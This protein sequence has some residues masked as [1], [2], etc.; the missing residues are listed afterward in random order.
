MTTTVVSNKTELLDALSRAGGGDTIVLKNGHYGSLKITADFSSTVT[1]RAEDRLG[2][3]ISG[4]ELAGATNLTFDG[5]NF[6]SGGNGGHGRGIVSA[7]YGSSGIAVVNSE[8]HGSDDNTYQG[9]YGLY[10]R[11]SNNVTFR[12]NDV[13]DVD[14]GIVIFG[15]SGSEISGN[16]V[17]YFGRDAMKFAG[18]RSSEVADNISY[19]HVYK[20]GTA[21]TDF[22]QFQGS[23][24]NVRIAGNAFLAG[25]KG[26]VQGIFLSDGTYTGITI[27]NNLIYTGMARGISISAGS[28][29][30]I[31]SNTLLNVPGV[32]HNQTVILAPGATVQDNI[33]TS[34]VGKAI[35]SNLQLQNR[36]PGADYYVE[37]YF[38]NPMEGLGASLKDLAPIAGSLGASKGADALL[39]A[40]VG[41]AAPTPS[42]PAPAPGPSAPAPAPTPIPAPAWDEIEVNAGGPA[43]NGFAA[44]A[45]YFRGSSHK[46]KAA[47]A[48]TAA[49]ALYQTERYGNFKYA[50]DVED[51]TY[52]VTLKMAEIYWGAAGKRVFDVKAEGKVVLDNFDI[53][54]AAG[55]KNIAHDETFTVEV[56]DGRLDLDFVSLV[57]NAKVSA[58]AVDLI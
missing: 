57:N 41:G 5:I 29:N 2:A 7:D 15:S 23:S 24:S 45:F 31:E 36:N 20:I 10:A 18:L 49:D 58:I 48:G 21:H 13:H 43:A 17:D 12:N 28:G 14:S 8:V 47:I 40:L 32:I 16:K 42:E 50:L 26:D 34:Y 6:F 1:I 30:V 25:T 3:T 37:D 22:I 35:G 54:R 39:K 4:V 9:H 51:G 55:G 56:D 11:N 44:D 53:F 33:T 38:Q 52:S 46:T 19:G 27:E